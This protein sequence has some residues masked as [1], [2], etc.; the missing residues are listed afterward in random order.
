MCCSREHASIF[1][2]T[3]CFNNHSASD[4]AIRWLG[5]TVDMRPKAL[6]QVFEAR[7]PCL[8]VQHHTQRTLALL[9]E[10]HHGQALQRHGREGEAPNDRTRS[11]HIHR[12]QRVATAVTVA[13]V[14]AVLAAAAACF[15]QASQGSC[16]ICGSSTAI[17]LV[18]QLPGRV[19]SVGEA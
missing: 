18:P 2:Q 6:K 16:R 12:Q 17:Q 11:I 8:V 5:N 4:S 19:Q 10:W 9:E 3:L 1:R 14:R 7:R 13:V 15:E